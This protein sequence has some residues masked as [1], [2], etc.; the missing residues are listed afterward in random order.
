[1]PTR[2]TS[3]ALDTWRQAR[4]TDTGHFP[5]LA[6]LEWAQL[7]RIEIFPGC[8]LD[9]PVLEVPK[10]YLP[11]GAMRRPASRRRDPS[12]GG[13]LLAKVHETIADQRDENI[14]RALFA[15]WLPHSG[16]RGGNGLGP[17]SWLTHSA[18]LLRAVSYLIADASPDLGNIWLLFHQDRPSKFKKITRCERTR[19]DLEVI[20]QRLDQASRRGILPDFLSSA[21]PPVRPGPI[22]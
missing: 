8:R 21:P 6:K 15:L 14:R 5:E 12:L 17:S 20:Y 4:L 9:D 22:N 19:R 16:K 3:A 7:K 1:M 11:P 18:L 13:K 10:D 2:S